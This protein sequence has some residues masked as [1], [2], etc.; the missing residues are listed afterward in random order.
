M[1]IPN[2]RSSIHIR[3]SVSEAM[4]SSPQLPVV[5]SALLERFI[6]GNPVGQD[7]LETVSRQEKQR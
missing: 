6:S 5:D 7:L 3:D 4:S 2:S 1:Q